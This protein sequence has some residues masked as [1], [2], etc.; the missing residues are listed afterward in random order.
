MA[1]AGG[2]EGG[3]AGVIECYFG[4]P[5]QKMTGVFANK[6]GLTPDTAPGYRD[7]AHFV[8]RG[9]EEGED[10]PADSSQ[11]NNKLTSYLSRLLSL[12]TAAPAAA[13]NKGFWWITNN[14]YLP[15]TWI[16]LTRLPKTLSESFSMIL[17]DPDADYGM[18]DPYASS[19]GIDGDEDPDT[20]DIQGWPRWR[21]RTQNRQEG[22]RAVQRQKAGRLWPQEAVR[23]RKSFPISPQP[24]SFPRKR[25]SI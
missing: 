10:L 3:V 13:K 7:I 18:E 17:A 9:A 20:F 8:F 2:G 24:S 12:M 25:E 4:T 11:T 15:A 1:V 23:K 22:R 21:L 14:P 6:L 19:W 5:D 16:N